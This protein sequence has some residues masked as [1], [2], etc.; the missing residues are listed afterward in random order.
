MCDIFLFPSTHEGF[1]IVAIKASA[2]GLPV[3]ENRIL[4]I[5]EAVAD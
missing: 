4:G 2:A 3:V 1:A 5:T